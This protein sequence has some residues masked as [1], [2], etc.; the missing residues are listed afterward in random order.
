MSDTPVNPLAGSVAISGQITL[1][2]QRQPGLSV[3]VW[4]VIAVPDVALAP[5]ADNVPMVV[6]G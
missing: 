5:V 3:E 2:V 4:I 6:R 1:L